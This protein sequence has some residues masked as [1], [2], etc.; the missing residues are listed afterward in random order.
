MFKTPYYISI[1]NK[2]DEPS[3]LF[4]EF[5][6]IKHPQKLA[7]ACIFRYDLEPHRNIASEV[8]L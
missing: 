2:K 3:R 5:L 6:Q 8:V 4:Y 1:L 7:S